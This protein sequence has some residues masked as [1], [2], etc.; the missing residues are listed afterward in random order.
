M[1][2]LKDVQGNKFAPVI[3]R[4]NSCMVQLKARCCLGLF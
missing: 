2:Q 1:V 4:F 3:L